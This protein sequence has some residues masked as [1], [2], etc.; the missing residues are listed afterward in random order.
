MEPRV[1][2]TIDNDEPVVIGQTIWLYPADQKHGGSIQERTI[3]K[4]DNPYYLTFNSLSPIKKNRWDDRWYPSR[5][6][7]IYSTEEAAEQQRQL[8][9]SEPSW[10]RHGKFYVACCATLLKYLSYKTGIDE[11]NIQLSKTESGT[12]HI[13]WADKE[14]L[15]KEKMKIGTFY[16]HTE[17]T[18]ANLVEKMKDLGSDPQTG[19]DHQTLVDPRLT[20][21]SRHVPIQIL[22]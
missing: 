4:I 13:A 3:K 5:R 18:Y 2:R 20:V 9:K 22:E 8:D 16:R 6:I 15:H 21:G 17:D 14:G 1:I 7:N 12:L 10:M 19:S 11:K